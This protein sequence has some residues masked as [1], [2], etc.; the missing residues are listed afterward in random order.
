[1]LLCVECF[2]GVNT[3]ILEHVA[4]HFILEIFLHTCWS[5]KTRSFCV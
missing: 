2:Y 3:A 1:M 5:V 4:L